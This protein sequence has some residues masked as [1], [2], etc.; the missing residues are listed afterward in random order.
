MAAMLLGLLLVMYGPTSALALSGGVVG[1]GSFSSGGSS[2]SSS[3]SSSSSSSPSSSY[4]GY[5]YPSSSGSSGS[6]ASSS[7]SSD[8]AAS[9]EFMIIFGV[10][11]G[12]GLLVFGVTLAIS[13]CCNKNRDKPSS[14][15]YS[16][17]TLQVYKLICLNSVSI[18]FCLSSSH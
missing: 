6:A 7:G 14:L 2:Y 18:A 5:Y 15:S 17:L 8:S 3:S 13:C 4:S 16:V 12:A 1:G 11:L 9:S 10:F